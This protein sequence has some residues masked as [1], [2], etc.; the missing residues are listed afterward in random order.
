[1]Y[2]LMLY[3]DHFYFL[4]LSSHMLHLY[5]LFILVDIVLYFLNDRIIVFHMFTWMRV[6]N[7]VLFQ[8][9]RRITH[10]HFEMLEMN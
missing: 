7:C 2:L 4:S 8:N 9:G 5:V 1:M 3:H 6:L 10:H